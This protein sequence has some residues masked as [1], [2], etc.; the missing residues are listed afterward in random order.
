MQT[1]GVVS[2]ARIPFMPAAMA[3]LEALSRIF[4]PSEIRFSVYGLREGLLFDRLDPELRREDPLISAARHEG[5][6]LSRFA[7][8]GDGISGWLRPLFDD[9]PPHL[10]RLRHAACL[11]ADSAWNSHPEYRAIYAA[12][13]AREGNWPGVTAEDR[14]IL[15]GALYAAYG[16]KRPGLPILAELATEADLDRARLWG[17]AIRLAQRLDGGTGTAFGSVDLL[18]RNGKIC[19]DYAGQ[20]RQLEASTVKRRLKQLNEAFTASIR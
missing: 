8:H 19:L 7:Y 6:R 2:A 14:A 18:M 11:L 16:G 4:V 12:G 1:S 20:Y 9:D 13:L 17:L 3:T 10:A 5:N 15:A